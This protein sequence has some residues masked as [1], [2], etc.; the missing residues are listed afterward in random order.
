A[1][2][3]R[4]LIVSSVGRAPCRGPD[5]GPIAPRAVRMKHDLRAPPRRPAHGF[6]IAKALVADRDPEPQP[7]DLEHLPPSARHIERLFARIELVLGL[8]AP[9]LT[10]GIDDYRGDHPPRRAD[11]FHA[12]DR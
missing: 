11:P 8:N 3:H 10:G 4:L 2:H 12:K 7:I 6:G 5:A 1:T 9:Y